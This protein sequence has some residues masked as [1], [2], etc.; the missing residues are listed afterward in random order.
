[1][2]HVIVIVSPIAALDELCEPFRHDSVI[3][4]M[5]E[6][7]VAMNDTNENTITRLMDFPSCDPQ[8]LLYRC[9]TNRHYAAQ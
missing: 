7:K 9:L 4:N 6:H 3:S 5:N 8:L 1:M 2:E